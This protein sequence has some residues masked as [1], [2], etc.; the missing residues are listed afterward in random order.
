MRVYVAVFGH[1]LR[2]FSEYRAATAAGVFTN[3][4]F[5]AINAMVLL[6]VFAAQPRIN[7]YTAADA[8][9]QV[10]V[11]QA[12]IGPTA[13]MG[14]PLELSQ[15]I[16]TGDVA[17]D[18]LRP[19]HPLLWFLAQDLG[20]AAYSAVFRSV[21]TFS[22]GIVLFPLVLPP[23]PLRWAAAAA[24]LALASLVG[25]GLRYLYAIAGFWILDT[26][27]VDSLG[28]LLGPFCSGMVLPLVLFPEGLA[29]LLRALPWSA[30]VQVP[31]EILLGKETLP[32]GSTAGGL[33][34]QAA[35]AA[36]LL[37]LGAA[38]TARGTR[39]VA[40]QGG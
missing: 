35:W 9:T 14:P 24:A 4:V 2:R 10:Y 1:G 6:A 15:R 17:V 12:L 8:V 30:L 11:A 32:G 37:G 7:G 26:R 31:A 5:G 38:L 19:A 34:F 29:A 27:G 21:P 18:L 40:V 28:A 13:I 23:D 33:L 25:F 22:V 36:V 39:R 3:S 20:R 16:R